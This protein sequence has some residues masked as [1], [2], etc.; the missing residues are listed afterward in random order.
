MGEECALHGW[1][2][3]GQWEGHAPFTLSGPERTPPP[4]TYGAS[5]AY[6]I[7]LENHGEGRRSLHPSSHRSRRIHITLRF[8][9]VLA[10][11]CLG[12]GRAEFGNHILMVKTPHPHPAQI[13]PPVGQGHLPQTC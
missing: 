2:S 9:H 11:T 13:P 4:S 3:R 6:E 12:K 8:S 10:E 1:Q 7:P 5:V